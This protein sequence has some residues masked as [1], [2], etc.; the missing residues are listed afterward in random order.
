ML[1]AKQTVVKIFLEKV[2]KE[3]LPFM[4]DEQADELLR[5]LHKTSNEILARKAQNKTPSK[6]LAQMSISDLVKFVELEH[7]GGEQ[8][9][10]SKK[11]KEN[12]KKKPSPSRPAEVSK[13]LKKMKPAR[14]EEEEHQQQWDAKKYARVTEVVSADENALVIKA[15]LSGQGNH[16]PSSFLVSLDEFKVLYEQRNGS[17]LAKIAVSSLG[18][19]L[20][21][22]GEGRVPESW[23]PFV[24][25]EDVVSQETGHP[26]KEIQREGE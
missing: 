13:P 7:L 24:E 10:K 5:V 15:K 11:K 17:K 20:A 2:S 1:S 23:A 16:T 25:P 9:P 19:A 22:L 18:E 12:R 4:S 8:Q 14:E 21:K 3:M 26:E 6:K